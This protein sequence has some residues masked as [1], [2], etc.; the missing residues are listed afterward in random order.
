MFC[1]Q[2]GKKL[3]DGARFCPNCGTPVPQDDENIETQ[4]GGMEEHVENVEEPIVEEK[5]FLITLKLQKNLKIIQ[6]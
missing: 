3:P 4:N 2:C 1:E 5:R 6:D